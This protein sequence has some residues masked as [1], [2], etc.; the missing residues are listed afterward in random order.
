MTISL[1]KMSPHLIWRRS[2]GPQRC[3]FG[4]SSA[5]PQRNRCHSCCD[6]AWAS[7]QR[8]DEGAVHTQCTNADI[9][10]STT[11]G[12]ISTACDAPTTF[13]QL[14]SWRLASIASH[15]K[16]R[17]PHPRKLF[18]I[19]RI[20]PPAWQVRSSQLASLQAMAQSDAI[21]SL[22]ARHDLFPSLPPF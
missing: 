3:T 13:L 21:G 19:H 18:R 8:C 12:A 20:G 15:Y 14:A 10:W 7:T 5:S 6:G 17:R 9:Q 11:R 2:R 16:T 22:V 4:L 1:H